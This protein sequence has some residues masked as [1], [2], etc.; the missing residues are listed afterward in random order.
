MESQNNLRLHVYSVLCPKNQASSS[1]S[2]ALTFLALS[3]PSVHA[4]V[5][6]VASS[7]ILHQVHLNETSKRNKESLANLIHLEGETGRIGSLVSTDP[8]VLVRLECLEKE[9]T[10][11]KLDLSS[12]SQELQI[13]TIERDLSTQATDLLL[14]HPSLLSPSA[15]VNLVVEIN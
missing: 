10:T 14:F 9:N 11:L 2:P 8:N 5:Q 7:M 1:C 4:H 6:G 12:C 15:M 3:G 13:K